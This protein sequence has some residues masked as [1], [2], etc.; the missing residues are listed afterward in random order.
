MNA[1][2]EVLKTLTVKGNGIRFKDKGAV[3]E[4]FGENVFNYESMQSKLSSEHYE[5][6]TKCVKEGKELTFS[7]ANAI[8]HAM[9]EWAIEKGATHYAHWFQPLTG[10]T[11]EKHDS[12]IEVEKGKAIER[13]SGK[14]LV[15]QEPDASS[16]PS[17]GLRVTFEARGYTAWDP[18]SPAFLMES[19]LGKTLCIPSVFISYNGEA[20]D[21]KA[22]LLKSCQVVQEKSRKLL[23]HFNIPANRVES[24]VGP[25]QEY[26]LVDRDIALLRPDLLMTGRTLFGA[27]PSKGQELDDQYFG[28]IKD[29]MLAFMHDI[30]QELYKLGIPIKTRHNEVAPHQYEIAPIY[31]EANIAADHN[32]LVME[33]MKK[34]AIKHNFFLSLH[35]KPFARINGSGK[36]LNWSL[37]AD[38][39]NLLD[40]GDNPNENFQ[41]LTFLV[42]IIWAVHQYAPLLRA[43]IASAGNDHRLG[44]NEAPPAI[45]SIFLGE[46]LTRILESIEKGDVSS[47]TV[48]EI[49][50]IGITQIPRIPRDNTDR[51]R[52]SP[53]AFTGNKFE[54]RA[55]GSAQSIAIPVT[56]I[57][58]IVSEGLEM[59]NK[60]LSQEM[61]R[62][63]PLFEAVISVI[64]ELIP[65]IKTILFEGDNYSE[66]WLKEAE[67]R[68]L[69]NLK[70]TPEALKAFVNSEF[71]SLFSS[72]NIFSH[73]ELSARYNVELEKYCK[74]IL[75]EASLTLKMTKS[76]I[77]PM[78]SKYQT[79]LAQQISSLKNAFE[80]EGP[81]TEKPMQYLT[82]YSKK[83]NEMLDI[84]S[85]LEKE[86]EKASGLEDN[87]ECAEFL[88]KKVIPS[89]EKLRC[90]VDELELLTD[91]KLWSLP[92]Y[93]E[94]LFFD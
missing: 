52:T 37:N 45:I 51:N 26:F 48:Q 28:S 81:M 40:P 5:S 31:E 17:G 30:E 59:M 53:F 50:N 71:Q 39:L 76:R 33:I 22:P 64:K 60:R 65:E 69:P 16:F 80:K 79:A 70:T 88:V 55:V 54:F 73:S 78:A 61:E 36:H 83:I 67:K 12:F 57:N 20:L 11:A 1:R 13:F 46:Q 3:S 72:H 19:D 27:Q 66:E 10:A 58:T 47:E 34:K 62:G 9:K 2:T 84:L 82:H 92:K 21:K 6:F 23:K 8:A 15:K 43:S 77:Y 85:R 42:A 86:I 74:N 44:G 7:L 25:E 24:S 93:C 38:G 63:K 29:R 91:D 4:Y 56:V 90:Y 94:L 49:I 35:E 14:Q 18:T 89:M 75:I 32:Q 41:F 68:H 87:G